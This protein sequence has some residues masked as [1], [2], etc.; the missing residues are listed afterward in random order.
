MSNN[1]LWSI[2][3]SQEEIA[4]WEIMLIGEL[5]RR[6]GVSRDTVRFYQRGGLIKCGSRRAGSRIYRDYP[7]DA[8]ERLILIKQ[9]KAAGFTLREVKYFFDLYGSDVDAIP[10]D[11]QKK[12]INAK[13]SEIEDRLR[14]LKTIKNY[15]LAQKKEIVGT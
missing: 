10:L 2:I 12:I 7:D 9:A 11:E 14:Q 15:L 4:V 1:K 13:L 6:A 5:A 8:L 3:H